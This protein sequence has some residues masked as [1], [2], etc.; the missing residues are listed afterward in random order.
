M[1]K[2]QELFGNV[3]SAYLIG[4]AAE[5]FETTLKKSGT[6]CQ[7]K[8]TLK[9]ALLCATRDALESGVANPIVLLSPACASF[10]QFKNFE[11]RGDAFREQAQKLMGIEA[12][13]KARPAQEGEAA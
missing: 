9:M 12:P 5:D 7:I 13:K 4:E 1:Y 3:R 10:D 2:R 8:K 11:I 6:P